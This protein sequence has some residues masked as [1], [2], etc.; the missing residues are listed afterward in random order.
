M[1]AELLLKPMGECVSWTPK[2]VAYYLHLID[3]AKLQRHFDN[4]GKDRNGN[5]NGKA[6]QSFSS[7]RGRPAKSKRQLIA[8]CKSET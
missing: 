2:P 6:R 3:R 4:N 8:R 5:G 1:Y 7:T